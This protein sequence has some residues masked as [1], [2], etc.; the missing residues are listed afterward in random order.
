MV[1]YKDLIRYGEILSDD[2]DEKENRRVREIRYDG[3]LYSLKMK[4]GE[5]ESIEEL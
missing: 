5:V 3:K 4:D 2:R 1:D